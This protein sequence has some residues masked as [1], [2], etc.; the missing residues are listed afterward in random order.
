MNSCDGSTTQSGFG[1]P[2]CSNA[3]V[4]YYIGSGQSASSI[5]MRGI[6]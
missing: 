5:T 6:P 4:G 2:V 3:P 1:S